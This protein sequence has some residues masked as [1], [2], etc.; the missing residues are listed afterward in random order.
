[1]DEQHDKRHDK[2]HDHNNPFAARSACHT[3]LE[4]EAFLFV[5]NVKQRFG[6]ETSAQLS[7]APN[8]TTDYLC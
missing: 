8:M 2:H 6:L 4:N 3:C 7:G 1:M 5:G